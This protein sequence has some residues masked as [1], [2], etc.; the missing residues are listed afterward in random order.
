VIDYQQFT[1]D[2]TK[3]TKLALAELVSQ[4]PG[5][6]VS[7]F[8]YETDDDIVVLTPLANTVEEHRRMVESG[9]YGEADQV[10]YLGIQEWPLYGVGSKYFEELS[11][12]VNQHVYEN[13]DE[14]SGSES[15]S[16]RKLN[17]LKS[18]GRALHKV[19]GKKGSPFL[20]V[21]NPDPGLEDLALYYC[22]A[23]LINPTGSMLDL[24]KKHVEGTLE[25]NGTTLE[26]TLRKLKKE[27]MLID[28]L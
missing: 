16:S 21:F 15:F 18:F 28:A 25:A 14:S 12:A 17:L 3:A 2:L 13:Q 5:E 20:A 27:G 24:Y 1:L 8:G 26:Q 22:I 4:R 23:R 19:G 10:D 11:E 7:I 9:F 6:T